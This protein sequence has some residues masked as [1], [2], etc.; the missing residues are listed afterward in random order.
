MIVVEFL[1]NVETDGSGARGGDQRGSREQDETGLCPGDITA[2]EFAAWNQT[3]ETD[4][5]SEEELF[6]KQRETEKR[7]RRRVERER[8]KTVDVTSSDA[9]IDKEAVV[10]TVRKMQQTN[11]TFTVGTAGGDDGS[12]PN[13]ADEE[14]GELILK[15]EPE[16]E[17]A[18][19]VARRRQRAERVDNA[20]AVEQ[21]KPATR[22]AALE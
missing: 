11:G 19:S 1:G 13:G 15:E 20:V 9:A 17:K 21:K 22:L 16:Q 7:G 10:K 6:E 12:G 2:E 18:S 8:K 14:N 5:R 3:D 4:R